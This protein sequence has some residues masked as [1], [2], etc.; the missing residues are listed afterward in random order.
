MAQ[1]WTAHESA[2]YLF[3]IDAERDRQAGPPLRK[4]VGNAALGGRG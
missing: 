2:G 1:D 4:R 3:A